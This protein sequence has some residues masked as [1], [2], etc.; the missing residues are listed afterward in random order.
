VGTIRDPSVSVIQVRTQE[1]MPN[2]DVPLERLFNPQSIAIV[3]ASQRVDATGTRVV[4]NLR[5]IGYGGRIHPV[6]PN[7]AEVEGLRCWPSLTTLPETV[8]AAFL[9]V[10]AA[11]GPALVE[12]AALCG[13][14][15]LFINANGYADG[16][17]QGAALQHKIEQSTRA[18]GMALCGPN[19]LGLVNVH[20]KAAIWTPRNMPRLA[21]GPLALI[22]QSGS[23]AIALA[24][25][26]RQLGFAYVVTTGNEAGLTVADYLG[27]CAR[28]D[29]VGLILLY[30]ETI[31]DVPHFEAAAREAG[32]RGKPIVALKLGRS[33]Q[34]RALVQAHTGSL[35]GEDSLYDALFRKFGIIRVNDLDEML[36]TAVLLCAEAKPAAAG[37]LILVTLS[38]GEAALAADLGA[39]I[40]LE[41]APLAESTL[42]RLRPAFP[43]Y[44][45]IRNPLDVWG[46][47]FNPDRFNIVL[48]ALIADCDIGTIA[49]ALDMPANGG[50]DAP[51]GCMIAEACVARARATDKRFMFINNITG[52]GPNQ[53]VRGILARVGIPI[54]SGI[55]IGLKA[56][57]NGGGVYFAGSPPDTTAAAMPLPSKWRER[58]LEKGDVGRCQLL[59][60]V[61]IPAAECVAVRSAEEAKQ[62]AQKLGFPLV[63]KGSAPNLFHKSELG[64]VRVGLASSSEVETAYREVRANLDRHAEGDG[65]REVYLQKQAGAGIE[66]V[67]AV[68]NEPGFG[69]FVIVGLGGFFI[70][71]LQ[72]TSVRMGPVNAGEARAMLSET[73]AS[74]LL[75]GFRGS[76]PYDVAAAVEAIAALSRFG[77]ATI[78]TLG[79]IEINPLIV[80]ERGATG[81]DILIEPAEKREAG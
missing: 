63:L 67:I 32:R 13:I 3:G 22:S 73:R 80:H 1:R 62:R 71:L 75:H 57:R 6:N 69:S 76:G 68:R 65:S 79:S 20:G 48:D 56:I 54:V 9:A 27:H 33:R 61:G 58:A 2:R 78:G 40:G 39:E 35:A 64:L 49:F 59:A 4:R 45:T 25:D 55:R 77:A 50:A 31:R 5:K 66:L 19:N 34:G 7:Y 23:V 17:A 43:P 14:R 21:E 10:P 15:A 16:D 46:L 74:Q 38:G 18:H 52:A 81:V 44:T 42:E 8:D 51:Y 28:D 47:G 53:Q 60:E 26:E 29:R 30:L 12:E 36:E 41:F 70:E 11:Q 72:E 24:E 37:G